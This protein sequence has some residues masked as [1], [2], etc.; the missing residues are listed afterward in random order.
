M[1]QEY[2]LAYLAQMVA[3]ALGQD[4][5]T[6]LALHNTDRFG[7]VHLYFAHGRLSR[8]EGHRASPRASL[9]DLATWHAG[10]IRRDYG[11]SAANAGASEHDAQLAQALT[12]AIRTLEANGVIRPAGPG[13]SHPGTLGTQSGPLRMRTP[14]TPRPGSSPL[15]LYPYTPVPKSMPV[16]GSMPPIMREVSQVEYMAGLPP[17]AGAAMPP[18]PPASIRGDAEAT[19]GALLTGP[20]WQL[21]ALVTHQVVEQTGQQ[22]GRQLADN[23]LRQAL[24]QTSARKEP[25]RV[26]EIDATGWLQSVP[27]PEGKTITDYATTAVTDAV[28]ALLTNYEQRCAALVGAAQ[29]QQA[30][31]V[32]TGPFRASLA[33]I[34]LVVADEANERR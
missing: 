24:G 1:E 20:Q 31:A 5:P 16:P 29:A 21:I 26:V 19:S 8:V 13:I 15:P 11:S 32:A 30:I 23:L 34:G 9:S 14:H 12:E 28:A 10:T 27:S 18:E 3:S 2:P 33:Q 6:R 7:L 4:R 17:L 25:L 22:I